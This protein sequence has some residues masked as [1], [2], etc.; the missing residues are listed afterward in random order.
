MKLKSLL[1][2]VFT[3]VCI[4]STAVVSLIAD[5]TIQK[6][7]SSKIRSE[8]S[9][10][11]FQ[12]ASEVNGWLQ[13]K[14]QVTEG[15]SALMGTGIS[16][17]VTPEYLNQVLESANIKDVVSDLYIGTADGKMIDGS[18][19]VPDAGYDPRTRLWYQ[20]AEKSEDISF[21]DVYLDMVTD[22]YVV[23][24]A[25]PIKSKSGE[26]HGVLAMDLQLE[27]I[28]KIVE[29]EK[30]GKTGYAF[31]IDQNGVI[32]AHPNTE[33]LNTNMSELKGMEAI[34][35]KMLSNVS[36]IEQYTYNN[37]DKLMIYKQLPS[38]SWVIGVTME[39]DE[40]NEE[41]VNSR[42]TFILILL[43]VC[44]LVLCIC[45]IAANQIA[46]P[47]KQLT[48]VALL[49]SKGD[50]GVQA[51]ENGAIEIR[52]LAKAF[53]DMS[54]SIRQLVRKITD[55]SDLVSHSSSEMKEMV[56]HTKMISEEI[57]NTANELANGAQSQAESATTG[58]E[59]VSHMSEAIQQITKASITSYQMVLD[60][61][62]SVQDGM[63]IIENQSLLMKKNRDST[64][65]VGLAISQL[66]DKSHVISKIV[67]VIRSIA[68]QT[69]LLALNA[70]I[71]AAR[72]GEHGKGFAVVADEVRN[73]AEQSAKSSTEIAKL[74]EDI[75]AKTIQSVDEV[76]D[77][78]KVVAEQEVSLEQ[79]KKLYR[80]I[81]DAVNL[82]VDKTISITE[83][84]N[85]LEGQSEKVSQS[86]SDVAAI[87]EESAAATEEVASSTFEQ[88][89]A[90]D[91]ING[92]VEILLKEA[93]QL[94]AIISDYKI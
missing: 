55:A 11:T 46:R 8:L 53:N 31:L 82:I 36:G 90:V 42:I 89:A 27:T 29:T 17:E 21:T 1:I 24:I 68:E 70:A 20:A 35:Q 71:E 34:T 62:S 50:L 86:I 66:E 48:E 52:N 54:G 9:S 83:E 64:E 43:F 16:K 39:A 37:Q 3:S 80:N 73:L 23:S 40:A 38:T 25:H 51:T 7:T 77:V 14:A 88:S 63:Q 49:A 45:F 4:G 12:L 93:A 47:I 32:L 91:K 84:T 78:Q 5:Q 60:V 81:E 30:I 41:I 28:T 19:W 65:K 61:S 94:T 76:E 22:K 79:T 26:F 58:A 6:Q 74:L 92:E 10:K 56:S 85:R 15:I 75:Q 18:F 2:I 33:L 59:M 72:A 69:N 87:T 67:E 13:G 57:S 44:A